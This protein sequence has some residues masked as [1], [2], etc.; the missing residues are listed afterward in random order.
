MTDQKL[1]F[2]ERLISLDQYYRCDWKISPKTGS[3]RQEYVEYIE[4]IKSPFSH[5]LRLGKDLVKDFK[6]QKIKLKVK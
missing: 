6:K 4:Y 1:H 3:K 5:P 2:V